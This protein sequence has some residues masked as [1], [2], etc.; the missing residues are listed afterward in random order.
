MGMV[1]YLIP[2]IPA[3]G[4]LR[5]QDLKFM[6]CGGHTVRPRLK[7]SKLTKKHLLVYSPVVFLPL[8]LCQLAVLANLPARL[9]RAGFSVCFCLSAP[10]FF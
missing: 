9:T 5:Q 4:D 3:L 8:L 2:V 1:G 7:N 10:F 6:A